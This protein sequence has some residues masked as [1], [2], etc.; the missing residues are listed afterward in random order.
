MQHD[1]MII[2]SCEAHHS[3]SLGQG[4]CVV[5]GTEDVHVRV[6]PHVPDL[7]NPECVVALQPHGPAS[8]LFC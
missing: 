5:V 1:V 4:I 8:T 6:P 2:E 7:V 3:L